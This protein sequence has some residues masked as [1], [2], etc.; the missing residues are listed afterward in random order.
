MSVDR[1]EH[2]REHDL[3]AGVVSFVVTLGLHI[4]VVLFVSLSAALV[5][6]A[7][8]AGFDEA[9]RGQIWLLWPLVA[10]SLVVLGLLLKQEVQGFRAHM[11][12][13]LGSVVV[14]STGSG[15]GEIGA[16]ISTA[17]IGLAQFMPLIA[18]Q[19]TQDEIP[20]SMLLSVLVAGP[21]LVLTGAISLGVRLWLRYRRMRHART[22]K[23]LANSY[24][25][26]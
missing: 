21:L 12:R 5:V 11:I 6:Y 26:E 20:R 2:I 8:T 22:G 17:L 18:M 13:G 9:A 14:A 23:T 19:L 4:G 10:V 1:D 25:S 15:V 7:I 3:W 16:D 24:K